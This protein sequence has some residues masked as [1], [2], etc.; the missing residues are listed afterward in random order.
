MTRYVIFGSSWNLYIRSFES[1]IGDVDVDYITF[2]KH[3]GFLKPLFN[4][5][6]S[7]TINRLFRIPFKKIWRYSFSKYRYSE[8]TIFIL[9]SKWILWDNEIHFINILRRNN[10]SCKIVLYLQDTVASQHLWYSNEG[11]DVEALKKQLD[12]IVSYN[13]VDCEKYRLLYHPT[14]YTPDIKYNNTNIRYDVFFIGRA[15]DRFMTIVNVLRR[16][17]KFGMKCKFIICDA[18]VSVRVYEEGLEYIDHAIPYDEN[19]KLVASSAC[20][21]ETLQGETSGYSFR[22]WEAITYGKMILT[23]N[24]RIME[25]EFYSQDN[26]LYFDSI[27]D[28]DD[29]YMNKIKSNK[30]VNYK[31]KEKMNPRQF[32]EF[33]SSSVM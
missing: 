29:S 20:V 33:I 13:H 27:D 26:I 1:V 11:I 30:K 22:V 19:L 28:I 14:V 12:L 8:Q 17:K 32:L 25:A 15:K 3:L 24:P 10:P 6:F 21:L 31:Y 18:P 23:N 16:L 5:H 2:E 9:F 7:Y 4:V